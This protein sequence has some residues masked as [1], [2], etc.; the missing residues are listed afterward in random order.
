MTTTNTNSDSVK[1]T[2][3]S[4]MRDYVGIATE[5]LESE[6]TGKRNTEIPRLVLVNA[7]ARRFKLRW[8]RSSPSPA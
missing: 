8:R 6:G 7:Q 4:I 5:R 1:R 2:L 3:D